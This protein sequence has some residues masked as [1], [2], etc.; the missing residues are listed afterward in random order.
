MT[1]RI[2][3]RDVVCSRGQVRRLRA[4]RQW[5]LRR[6]VQVAA[7]LS[8][9]GW[10]TDAADRDRV[11]VVCSTATGKP[12]T[13]SCPY[14]A[15]HDWLWVR[16]RW[17]FAGRGRERTVV[18]EADSDS[19]ESWRA[20][21]WISPLLMPASAARLW[22][23]LYDVRAQ[24][25]GDARHYDLAGEGVECPEHDTSYS[26]CQAE[27]PL[28]RQLFERRWSLSYPQPDLSIEA[29]P[30][31]WALSFTRHDTASMRRCAEADRV[32]LEEPPP[33]R[34]RSVGR[35]QRPRTVGVKARQAARKP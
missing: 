6:P 28:R 35:S 19:A 13:V 9:D 25:L 12:A 3:Q 27:C 30:W 11:R 14:G 1:T 2:Q 29:N 4:G 23:R 22:L 33:A 15:V 34:R 26:Y 32:A 21:A 24:R 17:A 16:E 18:Y 8:I 7:G 20:H 31:V 5:Q 10:V